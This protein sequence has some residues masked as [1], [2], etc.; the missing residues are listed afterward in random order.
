M[1]PFDFVVAMFVLAP[2]AGVA[3]TAYLWLLYRSDAARPRS[4]LLLMLARGATAVNVAV[5]WF[6]ALAAVRLL[7][8]DAPRW[9]VVPTALA[10]LLLEAV[11]VYSAAVMYGRGR[12]A[13]SKR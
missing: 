4:W 13:R 7:G 2:A 3:A 1:N 9:T 8:V 6:A 11:P 10:L 12:A 5:L